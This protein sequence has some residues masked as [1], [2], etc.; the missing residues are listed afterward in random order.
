MFKFSLCYEFSSKVKEFIY[1]N[2]VRPPILYESQAGRL[3]ESENG[4][5]Q[6]TM[7]TMMR[8]SL[9][10]FYLKLQLEGR[11][12]ANDFMLLDLNET[13]DQLV[14]ANSEHLYGHVLRREDGNLMRRALCL[15][16]ESGR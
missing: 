12:G 14:M 4:I 6:R 11:K 2:Y 3:N 13:I 5:L 1:K 16:I 7:K 8:A 9:L 10:F 15:N